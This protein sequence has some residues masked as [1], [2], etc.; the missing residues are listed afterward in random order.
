[1]GKLLEIFSCSESNSLLVLDCMTFVIANHPKP[2]S[3]LCIAM[4]PNNT[5]IDE[6][7]IIISK[8]T[9]TSN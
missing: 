9:R 5:N 1:M 8:N 2:F 6:A 7:I 3:S 4:I